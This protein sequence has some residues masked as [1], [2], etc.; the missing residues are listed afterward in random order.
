MTPRR[1]PPPATSLTYAQY[2]GWACCWCGTSLL[3]VTGAVSAGIARG[4]AGAHVLDVEVYACPGCAP[5]D[6]GRPEHH[7]QGDPK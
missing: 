2:A 5:P 6:P 3:D 7:C 4:Q 1:E